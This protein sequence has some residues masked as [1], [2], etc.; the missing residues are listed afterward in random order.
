VVPGGL[1]AV[2]VSE[3]IGAGGE[4]NP[5]TG[6]PLMPLEE[7]EELLGAGGPLTLLGAGVGG[8]PG[9]ATGAG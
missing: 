6:A 5:G 4:E 8:P 2:E 3:Q 7:E 1:V 9:K